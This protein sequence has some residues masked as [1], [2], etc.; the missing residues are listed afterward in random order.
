MSGLSFA[1][2]ETFAAPAEVVYD[3]LL[4][5]DFMAGGLPDVVSVEKQSDTE[6]TCKIRPKF[7]FLR[8]TIDVRFQVSDKQPP[9]K[10]TMSIS[11]KGIGVSMA[12]ETRMEV[13]A[14][15][16]GSTCEVL[17]ESEIKELGG[18]LKSVSKGLIQGA[19]SKVSADVW[20]GVHRRM[21]A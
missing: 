21:N 10:A 13:V 11:N 1:G 15:A 7:S 8:G 17:W 5:M 3:R 4:D 19:A 14:L 16:D 6:M 20:A 18:L 9:N 12:M 2:R